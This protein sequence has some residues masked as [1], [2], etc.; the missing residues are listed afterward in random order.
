MEKLWQK[1]TRRMAATDRILIAPSRQ[2]WIF[3]NY[4]RL[5]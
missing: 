3:I 4:E 2:S 1:M 5:W